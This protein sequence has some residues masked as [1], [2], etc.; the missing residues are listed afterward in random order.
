MEIR[1]WTLRLPILNGTDA[2]ELAQQQRLMVRESRA[3]EMHLLRGKQADGS[4]HQF[5]ANKN[6]QFG[7]W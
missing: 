1:G 7:V 6:P 5:K 4:P 2:R 3:A